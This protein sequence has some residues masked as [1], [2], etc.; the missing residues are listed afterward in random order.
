MEER[1]VVVTGGT[2]GIG[3]ECCR[4]LVRSERMRVVLVGRS[5]ERV[6]QAVARLERDAAEGSSVDGRVADLASLSDVRRLANELITERV[7]LFAMVCNAGVESPP[8]AVSPDGF[9]TTFATNHLGHF[10]LATSLYHSGRF[11]GHADGKPRLVIVS[12]SLHNGDNSRGGGPDVSDWERVA[13]GGE[14]WGGKTAYATTKLCNLFFGYEFQRRY[15]HDVL[16]YMYSPGFIPDTGL[17]RN[18]SAIGWFFVKS[19]LKLV[20][21]W[22]PRLQQS[23]STPER[24]GAFLARLASDAD[25]PWDSP[26]YFAIDHLFHTSEESKD[27][28]LARALWERSERWVDR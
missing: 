2:S 23:M 7:K 28:E 19:L 22:S 10:L 4:S 13:F 20:A 27:P 15:G 16:V 9:E 18:H 5:A 12:S 26:A 21:Y 25:L 8:V 11:V 14:G 1:V 24:S 17:F 3:L 6:Q